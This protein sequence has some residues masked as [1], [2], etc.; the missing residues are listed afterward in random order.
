[1]SLIEEALRRQ[2]EQPSGNSKTAIPEPEETPDTDLRSG[3]SD[4]PVPP[5]PPA[6]ADQAARSG[7]REKTST[8]AWVTLL[9][10]LIFILLLAGGS[11]WM[12]FCAFQ[13]W[14]G[15]RQA[16]DTSRR[17]AVSE[18][19]IKAA[20][21]EAGH[22]KDIG[23]RTDIPP[24]SAPE[25][26]EDKS[27]VDTAVDRETPKAETVETTTVSVDPEDIPSAPVQVEAPVIRRPPVDWPR[28]TL[29]GVLG[30]GTNGS[31][32]I[33]NEIV[34]VDETIEGVKVI[35]IRGQGAELEYDGETLFLK[36]GNSIQ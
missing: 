7:S 6:Q 25:L 8:R 36:V 12:M 22:E 20:P 23:T 1:M 32:I 35:S 13:R 27:A 26:M 24:D 10:V 5:P 18:S 2:R 19:A 9:G 31:V 29:S 28:L 21:E 16:P 4:E 15:T 33:D 3:K 34:G 11:F 14:K 30:H 17:P